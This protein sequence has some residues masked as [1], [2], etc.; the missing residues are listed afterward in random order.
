MTSQHHS[1]NSQNEI[2]RDAS[3]FASN[4]AK[5][6]EK[7]QLIMR[8]FLSRQSQ[9]LTNT[10]IDPLNVGGAF[11]ELFTRMAS[12]PAKMFEMQMELWKDY[13]SLWQNT[14]E[15]LLG[16]DSKPVIEPDSRDKRFKDQAWNENTVFDFLKQSYLLTARWMQHSVNDVAGIDDHN[17]KKIDF[18]TRQFVD[19]MS[20]SNF[21]MTN[22]EVL[23]AT[24]ESKGENLVNGLENMLED[25][26][27]G[28]DRK[29]VV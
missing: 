3:E 19:A 13:V 15:R 26:E 2:P 22:P 24:I 14:A 6:A 18:Y 12:D 27:R 1:N 29:S 9:D 17:A 21:L 10:P 16:E 25:I 7:C 4:M 11:F 20:P 8:E 23:K 28:G 5:A